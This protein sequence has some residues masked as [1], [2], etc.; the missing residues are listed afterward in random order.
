[1]RCISIVCFLPRINV[2]LNTFK[3]GWNNHPLSS[4]SG[5]SPIQLWISGIVR[6]N[7]TDEGGHVNLT[8]VCRVKLQVAIIIVLSTFRMITVHSRLSGFNSCVII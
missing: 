3:D 1:M 8:E 7:L 6:Q 5:L 2:P 4:E